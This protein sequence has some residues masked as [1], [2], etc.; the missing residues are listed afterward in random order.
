MLA[1]FE[2]LTGQLYLVVLVSRLVGLRSPV[3]RTPQNERRRAED[4]TDEE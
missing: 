3:D 4:A 1:G 2:A